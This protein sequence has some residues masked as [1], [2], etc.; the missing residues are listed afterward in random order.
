MNNMNLWYIRVCIGH[1]VYKGCVSLFL[2]YR[3]SPPSKV[4]Q[5]CRYHS[6]GL[7]RMIHS[8]WE[9]QHRYTATNTTSMSK[10]EIP[11]LLNTFSSVN[12]WIFRWV[13][14]SAEFLQKLVGEA[15][16]DIFSWMP[17]KPIN[18]YVGLLVIEWRRHL[19]IL[20]I[21]SY[22]LLILYRIFRF[23]LLLCVCASERSLWN[24]S[25]VLV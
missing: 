22:Q 8:K 15:L 16:M 19:L 12:Y 21:S 18:S 14:Y 1:S 9:E 2:V 11:S 5:V 17:T 4:K 7:L 13:E 10:I 3:W 23:Q 25:M 20:V 6:L 24:H